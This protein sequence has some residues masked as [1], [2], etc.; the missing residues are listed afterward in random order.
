VNGGYAHYGFPGNYYA[1]TVQSYGPYA[2]NMGPTAAYY[3][4]PIF[5][6]TYQNG[7][8]T[9]STYVQS[10]TGYNDAVR[11]YYN[12][13]YRGYSAPSPYYSY[14]QTGVPFSSPSVPSYGG[15]AFNPSG[16]YSH[17][18]TPGAP[19]AP[20]ASGTMGFGVTPNQ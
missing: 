1:P 14:G 19:T 3:G 20:M 6:I 4:M 17:Y 15:S 5:S 10:G 13:G 8:G 7:D 12:A 11:N 16:T 18:V 9:T 2:P